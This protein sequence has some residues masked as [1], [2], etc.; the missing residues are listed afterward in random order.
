[1]NSG[2]QHGRQSEGL[3]PPSTTS[4]ELQ[5]GAAQ[6]TEGPM[7]TGAANSGDCG[8]AA[9]GDGLEADLGR[10]M[11]E[12]LQEENAQLRSQLEAEKKKRGMD[13]AGTDGMSES[14]SY[15]PASDAVIPP[16]PKTPRV[17]VEAGS[18]FTTSIEV[19]YTPGRGDSDS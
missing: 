15:V 14:W 7:P 10:L 5:D 19:R 8:L 6:C 17:H 1:M 18:N 11:F 12:Q 2:T 4:S 13:G 16:P 9:G 3:L